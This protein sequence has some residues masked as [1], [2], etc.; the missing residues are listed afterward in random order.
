MKVYE[1][2][3]IVSGAL[4]EDAVKPVADGIEK[5]VKA[6]QGTITSLDEWGKRK[7][8]YQINKQDYGY[9]FVWRFTSEESSAPAEIQAALK[10]QDNVLRS[11][12]TLAPKKRFT[13]DA[14]EEGTEEVKET[15]EA[16]EAKT[17][18]AAEA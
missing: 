10:I 3:A 16:K 11:L 17:N 7:L 8:A 13:K 4:E 15:K 6:K 12:V 1:L 9:Y 2:M 14:V 18:Q 5:T